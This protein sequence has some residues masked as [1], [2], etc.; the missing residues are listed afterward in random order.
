VSLLLIG[1]IAYASILGPSGVVNGCYVT[2]T[3]ALS[4]LDSTQTCP[5]GQTALNWN[6]TG[7]AG[8][9]GAPGMALNPLQVATLHWYDA[10][11]S[12]RPI[13]VGKGP[14][15][16]A[17]DGAN[18]WTANFSDNTVTKVRTTD[19]AVLGTYPVG[20]L[21]NGVAFDGASVWVTNQQD[22]TVSRL[23]ASDGTT[24]GTYPVGLTPH[25]I[26]FD[27][28]LIW[29]ATGGN[30]V[31]VLN[32]HNPTAVMTHTVGSYPDGVAFDGANI[33]VTNRKR[34]VSDRTGVI[35]GVGLGETSGQDG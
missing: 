30:T 9:Q 19:G 13:S 16:V 34:Q 18:I 35:G 6:Q 32:A 28:R 10:N 21:P 22:G 27:G 12:S 20:K 33:W 8:P 24:L 23:Q 1:S 4:V 5:A 3:G 29:I 31:S 11:Q 26:A 14:L 2:A 25:G 17:F 15:G 7:P